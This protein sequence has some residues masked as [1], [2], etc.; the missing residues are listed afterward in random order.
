MDFL[1]KYNDLGVEELFKIYLQMQ[2]DSEDSYY[3]DNLIKEI[4]KEYLDNGIIAL[5]HPLYATWDITDYCNLNCV[6]CSANAPHTS[7]NKITSKNVLGIADSIIKSGI[8]YVSIRGGE[9]TLCQE[10]LDVIVKLVANNI[11]VEIVSNGRFIDSDFLKKIKDIPKSMLRIKISFDSFD[12][13]TNDTQRGKT[14]Y[15]YA[16]KAMQ[17]CS[18]YSFPF[19]VQMVITQS[20]YTHIF[21]TYKF[22]SNLGATSFGVI[23]LLPI[24]RGRNSKLKI[25]LNKEILLQ[26]I[27]ILDNQKSTVLEKI[28]LGVDAVK[29]YL[30]FLDKNITLSDSVNLGHIKCNGYKTRI[31]ISSTGDVFP[32]DLLRYNEFKGGNII[33]DDYWHS[34]AAE[35][36]RSVSR[37]NREKCK[38]C[39]ILGCNMGC[40]AIGMEDGYSDLTSII[41]NCEV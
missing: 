22:V 19:R 40:I 26:L 30:P 2:P 28:G 4:H 25:S 38:D 23:L 10:L 12:M 15:Y 32:C 31:Y 14:S 13:K 34:P 35:Y 5:P 6:F 1:S 8:K 33:S 17:S 41:P 18:E 9:P 16:V 39:K 20:N 7:G 21:E 36:V 37:L 3:P 27:S 29:F 24:G 11:F